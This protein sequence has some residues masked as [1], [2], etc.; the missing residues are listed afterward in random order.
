MQFPGYCTVRKLTTDYC[1]NIW[2]ASNRHS[3]HAPSSIVDPRCSILNKLTL[4][5]LDYMYEHILNVYQKCVCHIQ[6]L[7]YTY[8]TQMTSNNPEEVAGQVD[9]GLVLVL[10]TNLQQV[11]SV[12]LMMDRR[13]YEC[14]PQ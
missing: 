14:L 13:V 9:H 8:I 4:P 6:T 5:D 7:K 2:R 11:V 10:L 3:A 12:F 1:S